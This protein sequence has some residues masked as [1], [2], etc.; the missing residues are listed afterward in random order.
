MYDVKD[1]QYLRCN[2]NPVFII[3]IN[4]FAS[5]MSW[6]NGVCEL[7]ILVVVYLLKLGVRLCG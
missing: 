5:E 3:L 2:L 6:L 1:D 7:H 4:I